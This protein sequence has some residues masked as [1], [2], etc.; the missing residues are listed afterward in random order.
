MGKNYKENGSS[1]CQAH[2]EKAKPKL[3]HPRVLAV[4]LFAARHVHALPGLYTSAL[5]DFR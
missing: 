3:D 2:T 4:V 1:H 5:Y